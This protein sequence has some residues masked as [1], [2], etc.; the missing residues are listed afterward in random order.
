MHYFEDG[1]D[2]DKHK[3][4]TRQRDAG[5][6]RAQELGRAGWELVACDWVE[7]SPHHYWVFKRPLPE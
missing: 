2:E 7:Y 1:I 6:H 5:F 4:Q 3:I